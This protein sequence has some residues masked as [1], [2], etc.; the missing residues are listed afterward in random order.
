MN[1]I[2]VDF[3]NS[4]VG[5][6]GDYAAELMTEYQQSIEEG[7]DISEYENLFK[8]VSRMPRTEIKAKM[9]DA[10]FELVYTAG[11]IEGYKYNEPSDLEGI[12]ALRKKTL[13]PLKFEKIAK[14]KVE[15]A[16]YGRIAGCLLG[17]PIEGIRFDK[18]TEL[19][20]NTDNYPM[21]RYIKRG[22]LTEDMCKQANFG[23]LDKGKAHCYI[24]NLEYAPYDD[25]TN[26]VVMNCL[27]VERYGRDF[28]P[29]LMADMWLRMQPKEAYCTAERVAITNFM[30]G[31]NPPYSAVHKNPYRE[32]IGAQIRGDYF[33]YCNPGDPEDAARMAFNDA[34]ISHIKNGI[35][36]EMWIAATIAAAAVCKDVRLAILYG[37]EEIPHTSRLYEA[38]S[39]VVKS[40]D[41]G[42]SEKDWFDDFHKRW[43]DCNSHH[44][45]HTISN[46]EICAAALL[47]GNGEYTSSVCLAVQNGFDT[48]CNGATVGSVCGILNGIE[49]I[50][51][52]WYENL[53]GTLETSLCTYAKVAID[54][55][56]EKTLVH[57]NNK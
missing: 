13:P 24:D 4:L 34:S 56:V 6:W 25:D 46:A 48:D 49:G 54:E 2:P 22:E 18:L 37:M 5:W 41:E 33:G 43:N 17:K 30:R 19:L 44:W 51:K 31:Y 21:S 38:L 1:K 28:S 53:N 14:S 7:L 26:Y 55:F 42:M 50:D 40:Y 20:K 35:Y 12:K 39:N 27:T 10:L 23:L 3:K 29:F 16:W 52:C 47:Y 57:I 45:C 8:E 11:T 36:G 32:W 15:G 9:A